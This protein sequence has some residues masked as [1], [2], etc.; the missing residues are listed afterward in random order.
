VGIDAS[1]EQAALVVRLRAGDDRAF[2]VLVT[3]YH[4]RLVR[5]ARAFVPRPDLAEDAVQE[6]WLALLRGI[7]RFEG[8]SSLQSWLFQICANRARSLSA[9]ERP[10]IPLDVDLAGDAPNTADPTAD[11]YRAIDELPEAQRRVVVLRDVEGRPA[12]EVCDV[13]ALSEANQRVLLH[14]GRAR[15]RRAL[16]AQWAA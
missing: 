16:I 5:L 8:R 2:D 7:D 9:R 1:S 3:E 11:V 13:L 10:T 4:P 15:V 6:T 14:R 12:S